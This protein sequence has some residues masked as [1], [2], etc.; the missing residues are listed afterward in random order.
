MSTPSSTVVSRGGLR[1]VLLWTL[2]PVLAVLA[3]LAPLAYLTFLRDA[4]LTPAEFLDAGGSSGGG[5]VVVVAGA[6]S[7]H[8]IGSADFV[9]VLRQRMGG[10]QFVNAGVNGHTSADLLARTDE[11]I[12]VKPDAVAILVGTN[13]VLDAGDVE[14]DL[15][16]YR[17]DL[18][19]MA[20]RLN[21]ETDAK[22]AFYSLQPIGEDLDDEP[23]L[24]LARFNEVIAEVAATHGATYL[25]LNET[26]RT[27]IRAEGGSTPSEFSLASAAVAGAR[28][29]YLGQSWDEIGRGNGYT[30]LVD[31]V[32]L[33]D[34]GA[35]MAADLA[36]HWLRTP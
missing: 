24:R 3:V 30:V 32:H 34:R 25:P 19:A 23:N 36:E 12:A 17:E 26:L 9:S 33:N 13:N 7:V 35:A 16:G 20:R 8:G 2:T 14:S 28:H 18:D 27:T 5:P 29:Y 15:I 22:V 6:S 1:R 4:E 10:H 11:I 21:D 31:G